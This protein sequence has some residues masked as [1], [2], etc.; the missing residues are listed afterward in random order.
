MKFSLALDFPVVAHGPG[1]EAALFQQGA[2]QAILAEELGY[3]GVWTVEHH[4]LYEYAHCSAPETVLA[5]IAGRTK[6]IL[7]GHGIA[8]L[9]AKY[10]HP[11]RIAERAATLDILSGG[12]V[13]LGTGKSS[14]LVE[15]EAFSVSSDTVHAE[16][17]AGVQ[18][19]R[20][21]WAG[22]ILSVSNESF[23]I[24]AT[25]IVPRPLQK[26]HPPL[27]MGCSNVRGVNDAAQL[28][29]GA[30]YFGACSEPALAEQVAAYKE[31][32]ARR[33]RTSGATTHFACKAVAMTLPAE[34]EA[35]AYG[36]RGTAFY[37]QGARHYFAPKKPSPG[38]IPAIDR[39]PVSITDLDEGVLQGTA[40]EMPP[41]VGDATAA[42]AAVEA[43]AR[44]GVDELI[45]VMQLAFVPHAVTVASMRY[46]AEAV[47]PAFS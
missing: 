35:R 14:S 3:H 9:P 24:P 36:Q 37:N 25:Y 32:A 38:A 19:L 42:R 33:P 39:R 40:N 47:M 5:Y 18:L 17:L 44:A 16:W 23:Q 34:R 4:G 21:I 10:N 22:D 46:F 15:R 12:R 27:Y 11:I 2:E 30:L 41:I 45:L 1:D 13:R 31:A 43:Y 20:D 7:L 29:L 6:K 8:L 26:P 28:A